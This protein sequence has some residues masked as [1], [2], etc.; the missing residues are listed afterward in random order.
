MNW[1]NIYAAL[2]FQSLAPSARRAMLNGT[3]IK[4]PDF[5]S[6][7]MINVIIHCSNNPMCKFPTA[8]LIM[9]SRN[10]ITQLL[11][12]LTHYLT[13]DKMASVLDFY[14]LEKRPKALTEGCP[15]SW[16]YVCNVKKVIR[17]LTQRQAMDVWSLHISHK[18]VGEA[19]LRKYPK[20]ALEHICAHSS[21]GY[22]SVPSN[23]SII[24]SLSKSKKLHDQ[25]IRLL[26]VSVATC[27]TD[28]IP[29]DVYVTL[30]NSASDQDAINR[31]YVMALNPIVSLYNCSHNT[32]YFLKSIDDNQL[33][34]LN[35]SDRLLALIGPEGQAILMNRLK[36]VNDQIG[37]NTTAFANADPEETLRLLNCS[38]NIDDVNGNPYHKLAALLLNH[39]LKRTSCQ[40]DAIIDSDIITS[41]VGLLS[42]EGVMT[43][44]L[45][46]CNHT[47]TT[48]DQIDCLVDHA[49]R[50]GQSPFE[51]VYDT[52]GSWFS[53][54]IKHQVQL[55]QIN[56]G[57]A[58]DIFQ[59]NLLHAFEV[60]PQIIKSIV[61]PVLNAVSQS[62]QQDWAQFLSVAL[63]N[64]CAVIEF[65]EVWIYMALNAMEPMAYCQALLGLFLH[66]TS[67]LRSMGLYNRVK[68]TLLFMIRQA[69]NQLTLLEAL[70]LKIKSVMY[71]PT[72]T[73]A[74]LAKTRKMFYTELCEIQWV[75]GFADAD[76]LTSLMCPH[77]R[78]IMDVAPADLSEFCQRNNI[79]FTSYQ[80]RIYL[81]A[82]PVNMLECKSG[83]DWQYKALE[84]RHRNFVPM[85]FLTLDV[86]R[87]VNDRF[88][89][90]C[91]N[92]IAF[93]QSLI[94]PETVEMAIEHQ[95]W[96]FIGY[97]CVVAPDMVI[98]QPEIGHPGVVRW[99]ISSD[100]RL[101]ITNYQKLQSSIFYEILNNCNPAQWEDCSSA[102]KE[103]IYH[104]WPRYRI[105]KIAQNLPQT[106]VHLLPRFTSKTNLSELFTVLH[107]RKIWGLA[108]RFIHT[109][110]ILRQAIAAF[111]P[112]QYCYLFKAMIRVSRTTM[113]ENLPGSL[114]DVNELRLDNL[115]T[116]DLQW[117]IDAQ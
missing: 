6:E 61:G 24:A 102:I 33:I 68:N 48:D 49:L 18:A 82:I 75:G 53:R 79:K 8:T 71:Y 30:V 22:L 37:L 86:L 44:L 60:R 9:Y 112:E 64:N 54:R 107:Q 13:I 51:I 109:E 23:L 17:A 73:Q 69:T 58:N 88:A 28:N 80:L 42:G 38:A 16:V 15:S 5:D 93:T 111:S 19:I 25:A 116:N 26:S 72:R 7:N 47:K 20:A 94:T 114:S 63:C 39:N 95:L 99:L 92:N 67:R 36:M 46:A 27:A 115:S 35:W 89:R 83:Y 74:Q 11:G 2:R 45:I 96:N 10:Q 90:C 29:D 105:E 110:P 117:A 104:Q 70:Q 56:N 55:F 113:L 97:V 3:T 62:P 77:G 43:W 50:I 85:S 59:A 76:D 78:K 41:R 14:I 57:T 87:K 21:R 66:Q 81:M 101:I 40:I 31:L 100:R 65:A 52:G 108:D 4:R 32:I 34:S 103:L 106:L 98:N 12:R 84:L 91:K 1:E